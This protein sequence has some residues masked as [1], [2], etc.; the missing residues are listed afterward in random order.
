MP[1]RAAWCRGHTASGTASPLTVGGLSN[2]TSYTCTVTA[3]NA[4]GTGPASARSNPIT[5]M[6]KIVVLNTT[7]AIAEDKLTGTDTDAQTFMTNV[8]TWFKGGPGVRTDL[9]LRRALQEGRPRPASTAYR[10]RRRS[11]RGASGFRPVPRQAEQAT[12]SWRGSVTRAAP[13]CGTTRTSLATCAIASTAS[14]DAIESRASRSRPAAGSQRAAEPPGPSSRCRSPARA[15]GR[16]SAVPRS[17]TD[18]IGT[19][20]GAQ[21]AV[22]LLGRAAARGQPPTVVSD[23]ALCDR[24]HPGETHRL[25]MGVTADTCERFCAVRSASARARR[26]TTTNTYQAHG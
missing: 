11:Q 13:S 4:A 1:P 26:A 21:P 2:G 3:T 10:R 16:S 5:P 8:L 12:S 15:S 7:G 25:H 9:M 14:V 24:G 17:R 23:S 22:R 18:S 19:G 6:G 20:N